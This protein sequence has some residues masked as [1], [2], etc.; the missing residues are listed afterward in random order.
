MTSTL[1]WVP[2]RAFLRNYPS[3]ANSNVIVRPDPMVARVWGWQNLGVGHGNDPVLVI[4]HCA[5]L[6]SNHG[7][8]LHWLERLG[9]SRALYE[10]GNVSRN[11]QGRSKILRL[12]CSMRV[13]HS[14]V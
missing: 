6:T 2:S 8:K 11:A 3:L 1:G 14:D 9:K 13:V 4:R 5:L 12:M 10:R 7:D